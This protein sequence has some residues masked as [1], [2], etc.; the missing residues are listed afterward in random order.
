[1]RV[2][3]ITAAVAALWLGALA[4][5]A[6]GQYAKPDMQDVPTFSKDVAPILYKHCTSCHRDGEIAPMSLLTYDE[7]RPWARAI[8]DEV[9]EGTMPPWHAEAPHGTFLN[10]RGLSDAEKDTLVKWASNG[11]PEGD[12]QDLPPAP[13]YADGWMIGTPDAVFE[14]EEPYRVPAEGIVQY[15]HLYIPTN[16]TEPKWVKAIEVRPGARS[17]VHHVLVF[18]RATPDIQRTPVLRPNI[19]QSRLPPRT[20][21]GLHPPRT[22]LGPSRV[23]ATY[24]PGTNPQVAPEGTAF[25]LEPGGVLELQMHYTTTGEETLDRTKIGFVFEHNPEGLRE[26][27]ASQFLNATLTL[28]AGAADVAVDADLTFLQDTTVW[29][30]FPHTHLRGKKWL[31]V[32][33]LPDGTKKTVLDVPRYD[34]NWQTYYLFKEPLQVPQGSK[35]VST[36]WYDNSVGNRSNPDPKVDVKWG[37]QTWEEMQ[38]TGILFSPAAAPADKTPGTPNR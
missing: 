8:R 28:P 7:A 27:R 17:V 21:R 1:M 6:P 36:A 2:T 38:Y 4:S 31:Y 32:L 11:A 14:V 20:V 3:T 35:L 30:L 5:A 37:D 10:E 13:H 23:L 15:E 33:E 12:P 24:A 9:G 18:Y 25:R 29:G 26:V 22:G 16:F 34:F 19:E